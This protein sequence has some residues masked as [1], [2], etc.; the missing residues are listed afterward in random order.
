M[1]KVFLIER[2]L[3]PFILSILMTCVI[4][5]VSI[6]KALGLQGFTAV[7]WLNAWLWSWCVAFPTLLVLLPLVRR[8]TQSILH[9]VTANAEQHG[10]HN[11]HNRS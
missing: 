5:L 6:I 1:N 10:F 7:G 4:S 11:T 3:M 2:L 9:K 8:F